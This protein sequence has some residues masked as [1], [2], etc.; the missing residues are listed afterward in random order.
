MSA[1]VGY[2]ERLEDLER[3]LAE[4]EMHRSRVEGQLTEAKE[5][6]AASAFANATLLGELR[7]SDAERK[8]T[9]QEMRALQRRVYESEGQL[10]MA[11]CASKTSNSQLET[12][13]EE[14]LRLETQV[15]LEQD[16]ADGAKRELSRGLAEAT[17]EFEA[18]EAA[19]QLRI[20]NLTNE[21]AHRDYELTVCRDKIAKLE[22]AKEALEEE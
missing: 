1:G 3:R 13:K 16:A 7:N 6:I 15:A 2:R 21:I 9:E 22:L 4:A 11:E 5:E 19:A 14:V 20:V 18:K 12:L 10:Q 17:R 8:A